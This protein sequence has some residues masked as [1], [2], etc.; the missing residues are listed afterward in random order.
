M[1]PRWI[2]KYSVLLVAIYGSKQFIKYIICGLISSAVHIIARWAFNQY[3]GF[4]LAVFLSYFVGMP[5]ALFLYRFFVFNAR[6]G[7][8]GRQFLLFSVTYFG[9]LPVT[10]LLSVAAELPLAALLPKGQ[11]ELFAHMIG[12]VAP[13]V[14]N[15]AYNK[16]ITFGERLPTTG[17]PDRRS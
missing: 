1:Q 6:E 16:F 7:S 13:V 15:F 3:M 12:V 9:F 5:V 10:W 11:A 14:I 17:V 2:A 8:V 4:G